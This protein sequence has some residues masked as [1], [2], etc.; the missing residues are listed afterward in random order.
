MVILEN[1]GVTLDLVVLVGAQQPTALEQ[2]VLDFN[3]IERELSGYSE[4]LAG[5]PRIVVLSKTDLLE[6]EGISG[7]QEELSGRLGKEVFSISAV[8]G[9]GVENLLRASG[10]LVRDAV[11]AAAREAE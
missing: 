3:L 8:T 7:F 6:S 10:T 5:K 9:D 11:A 2:V 1:L 4:E